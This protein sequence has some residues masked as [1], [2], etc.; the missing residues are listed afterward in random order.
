MAR[1]LLTHSIHPR[2]QAHRADYGALRIGSRIDYDKLRREGE[3]R[4][5]VVVRSML[6][7]DI[8]ADPT[9]LSGAV[10]HGA[11]V[12]M[13]PIAAASAHGVLVANVPGVNAVT[14][15][16]HVLGQMI[17]LSRGHAAIEARTRQPGAAHWAQARALADAGFDLAGRS[18]GLVGFGH[19]GQAVARICSQGF[20][21][22][23]RSHTR[24]GP[25][26]LEAVLRQSDFVVLA[27]PLTEHTRGLIG[28]EQLAQM[29]AGA[30]LV[31]VARGPVVNEA[32]LL[33]ALRS[34]HLAGAALDVFDTQPLPDDH[35]LRSMTQVLITPHIA[36]ISDDSMWRMGEAVARAVAAVLEGRV[37]PNCINPDAEAAF[38]QRM[39]RAST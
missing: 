3:A 6:Q 24:S 9:S 27:C 28:A 26:T 35:P 33:A 22:Q 15:A 23:V 16:E 21:M 12:D 13:I 39:R 14:V 17:R 10:R 5:V 11:G 36:G 32:A 19:V 8:F 1:I 20:G 34:G 31:N 4:T 25:L 2:A 29:R 37:P 30:Y 38:L 7:D 18:V